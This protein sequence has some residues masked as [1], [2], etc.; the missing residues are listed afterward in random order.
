LIEIRK[1]T[2]HASDTNALII[3]TGNLHG[4]NMLKGVKDLPT[5]L[6]DWLKQVLLGVAPEPPAA[7]TPSTNTPP[8]TTPTP[9]K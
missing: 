6:L 2:G 3:C 5:I 7:P 8:A 1:E 9:A 4:A